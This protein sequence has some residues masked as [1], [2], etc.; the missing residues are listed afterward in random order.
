MSKNKYEQGW[1][2]ARVAVRQKVAKRREARQGLVGAMIG[3]ALLAAGIGAI[4]LLGG[5]AGPLAVKGQLIGLTQPICMRDLIQVA[6]M[7]RDCSSDE[8]SLKAEIRGFFHG[9]GAPVPQSVELKPLSGSSYCGFSQGVA[10]FVAT[11]EYGARNTARAEATV[12]WNISKTDLARA[13]KAFALLRAT[14]L[15]KAV[16]KTTALTEDEDE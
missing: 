9:Q 16:V 4:A 7:G 6:Q 3:L 14:P 1:R 10:D 12:C 11:P 5:C 2:Q 15:P 13:E 8:Q